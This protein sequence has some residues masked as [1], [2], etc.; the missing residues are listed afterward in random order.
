MP[1]RGSWPAAL[2]RGWVVLAHEEDLAGSV[3]DRAASVRR[4]VDRADPVDSALRL[5]DL[6]LRPVA[7]AARTVIRESRP[8]RPRPAPEII[9]GRLTHSGRGA[10]TTSHTR[11]SGHGNTGQGAV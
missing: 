10:I 5:V 2:R 4:K 7:L 1:G 9:P 6:A 3:D 8:V 11:S